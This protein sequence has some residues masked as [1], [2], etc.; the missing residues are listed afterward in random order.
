MEYL[1][2]VNVSFTSS[3]EQLAEV[4]IVVNVSALTVRQVDFVIEIE[5]VLRQT[6]LP[7]PA[8]AYGAKDERNAGLYLVIGPWV[9][10]SFMTTTTP[11]VPRK[12][13]RQ[14]PSCDLRRKAGHPF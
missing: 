11:V 14:M 3:S 10:F 5:R 2:A 8:S 1:S 12:G 9:W 4:L 6:K 13:S 7:A